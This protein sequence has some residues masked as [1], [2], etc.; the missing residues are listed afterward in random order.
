[1][2]CTPPGATH[3]S[4]AHLQRLL[5]WLL[6]NQKDCG[7][8]G[9]GEQACVSGLVGTR[10]SRNPPDHVGACCHPPSAPTVAVRADGRAGPAPGRPLWAGRWAGEGAVVLGCKGLPGCSSA[11]A[12]PKQRSERK[13]HG[14]ASACPAAKREE[15]TAR[16]AALA[17]TSVP[18]LA[19]PPAGMFVTIQCSHSRYTGLAGSAWRGRGGRLCRVQAAGVPEP[20]SIPRRPCA[21]PN[22]RSGSRSGWPGWHDQPYCSWWRC[23]AATHRG[24]R[25][26]RPAA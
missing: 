13:R 1:M 15:C 16:A 22:A 26:R 12:P 7:G 8:A 17:R 3:R 25:G 2:L 19:S 9:R 4:A 21:H 10:G 5:V 11:R 6:E 24:G 18:W 23:S 14:A 20:R